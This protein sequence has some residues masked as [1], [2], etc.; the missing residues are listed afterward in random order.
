MVHV[1]DVRHG[2][3]HHL[4]HAK[5]VLEVLLALGAVVQGELVLVL[6]LLLLLAIEIATAERELLLL[7]GMLLLLLLLLLQLLLRRLLAV[8]IGRDGSRGREVSIGL[9]MLLLL[10]L[11]V[12]RLLLLLWLLLRCK[13]G[14]AIVSVH[15]GMCGNRRSRKRQLI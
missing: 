1:A 9:H 13:R 4:L 11:L 5:S 8:V 15:G 6:L 7:Q 3:S 2:G 10:L 12:W 14:T